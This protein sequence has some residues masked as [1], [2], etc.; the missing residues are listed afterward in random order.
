MRA[1]GADP[2]GCLLSTAAE[3]TQPSSVA[4]CP[5]WTCASRSEL[6]PALEFLENALW[7]KGFRC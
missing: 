7:K 1:S 3:R 4:G 2:C 6:C 5:P